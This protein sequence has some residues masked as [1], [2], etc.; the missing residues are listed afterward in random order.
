[1][2]TILLTESS[3]KI[4]P[5]NDLKIKLKE[6]QLTSIYAMDQ[7]EKTGKV[8]RTIKSS[9]YKFQV[10]PD[11]SSIQYSPYWIPSAA[12]NYKDIKYTIETNFGVLADVVGSGKT[13][14]IMGLLNYNLVPPDNE[15]II[16]TSIFSSLKYQDV[17][18][19]FKTNLIIVPHNL[20]TQWKQAFA[21]CKLKTF[22]IAKK[23]DI[24]F[25]VYPDNVFLENL[26]KPDMITDTELDD[27]ENISELNTI[28]YYDT[29]ICSA[30]MID[31]YI[32][33]FNTVKYSRIII[34]EVCSIRLPADLNWKANFIWFITATP[35]G[36]QYLKRYYIKDIVNGMHNLI[37][38][39]I[40]IKNNDEY[41]SKSMSLPIINQI[42]SWKDKNPAVL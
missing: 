16:S 24:N 6:H 9:I 29:I 41:V 33:K 1:M 8:E 37:F 42:F 17:E 35:S 2:T 19:S 27:L 30:T 40:I 39:N 4:L 36:L 13:Y 31:D 18:K 15:K 14:M 3:P 26:D 21:T 20:V 38:D 5:P 12:R 25:L 32:E 22:I 7:L 28:E 11:S 34:D 23:S 10:Y